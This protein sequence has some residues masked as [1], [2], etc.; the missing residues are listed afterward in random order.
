[1]AVEADLAGYRFGIWLRIILDSTK[2][3]IIDFESFI[4]RQENLLTS[5]F[6]IR[7]YINV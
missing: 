1:M 4:N 7:D 3:V 5:T 6:V 2:S